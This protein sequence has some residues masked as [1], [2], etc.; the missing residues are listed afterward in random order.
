MPGRAN[1]RLYFV[2]DIACNGDRSPRSR[3]SVGANYHL[4][5]QNWSGSAAGRLRHRGRPA[6]EQ[7]S[8]WR[9]R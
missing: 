5:S 8:S 9:S 2:T 6:G 3:T 1:Y 7:G 4:S